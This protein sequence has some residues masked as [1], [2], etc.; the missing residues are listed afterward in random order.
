[1]ERKIK[2]D[3]PYNFDQAL[4]RLAP[5]PW[6]EPEMDRR[7]LRLGI[8]FNGRPAVV[9]VTAAGT[10]DRPEF[11]LSAEVEQHE[12]GRLLE[13]VTG[14]MQFDAP[15]ARIAEHLSLNGLEETV[16]EN[17]GVPFIRDAQLFGSLIKTIIHQQLNMAFAATLTNRFVEAFGTEQDGLWFFPSPESV[18]RIG[19]DELRSMQFSTRKAEYIIDTAKWIAGGG[20]DP[21]TFH[22]LTDSEIE[23]LLTKRRGIGRWTAENFMMFGLGRQDLFPVGDIGVQNAL[24]KEHGL[25]EKPGISYMEETSARWAPYRSYATLYLWNSLG[26]GPS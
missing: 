19:V 26:N 22:L 17:Y 2:L 8:L 3:G 14:I 4:R 23:G 7:S 11:L 13:Q 1:M 25:G 9:T 5:D 6:A 24:K 16:R 10:T 15:L 20:A 18:S 12:E 21:E